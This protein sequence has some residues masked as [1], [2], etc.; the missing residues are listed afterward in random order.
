MRAALAS[1]PASAEDLWGALAGFELKFK[2]L[3][4]YRE[5][6]DRAT[7]LAAKYLLRCESGAAQ[8]EE[9]VTLAAGTAG[10]PLVS[11]S[12]ILD[13]GSVAF[14]Q[15]ALPGHLE[16]CAWKRAYSLSMARR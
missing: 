7:A 14:L 4:G 1:R 5:R 2:P 10:S 15:R 6:A 9:R 13:A 3:N 11:D 12:F 8:E 16:G